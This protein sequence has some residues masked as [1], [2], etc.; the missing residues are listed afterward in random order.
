MPASLRDDLSDPGLE[1]EAHDP[2]GFGDESFPSLA[3]GLDDGGLVL[4]AQP[5]AEREE[6][7]PQ[8]QQ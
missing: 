8:E 4:R 1:T 6:A 3:T 5:D 2:A 7:F